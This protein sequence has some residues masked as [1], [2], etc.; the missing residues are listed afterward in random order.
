VLRK[1]C[2]TYILAV[3]SSADILRKNLI[4][5]RDRHNITQEQAAAASGLEYKY[6]QALEAGRRSQIRLVTL[7]KLAVAYGLPSSG[8]LSTELPPSQLVAMPGPVGRLRK[9]PVKRRRKRRKT[10]K[11]QKEIAV[12]VPVE[13]G[14]PPL[15]ETSAPAPGSVT[16]NG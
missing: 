4:L 2:H 5:L 9:K 8:L 1:W 13:P 15:I 7:D 11:R 12:P 3:L 16:D 6:Y 10:G 14:S